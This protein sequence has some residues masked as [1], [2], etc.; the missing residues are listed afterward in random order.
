[1]QDFVVEFDIWKISTPIIFINWD[2]VYRFSLKCLFLK[3]TCFYITEADTHLQYRLYLGQ[4]KI[5]KL[6]D[7][8]ILIILDITP[9]KHAFTQATEN[10]LPQTF[11]PPQYIYL[12][13]RLLIW[14]HWAPQK[15][16][17]SLLSLSLQHP[18]YTCLIVITS[19][20]QLSEPQNSKRTT[21]LPAMEKFWKEL[22]N[23]SVFQQGKAQME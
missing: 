10:T 11:S 9:R 21:K 16:L 23:K 20:T 2:E 22:L 18:V 17:P 7:T 19:Q 8:L 3:F 1:M 6:D 4:K 13:S 5:Q 15:L 12:L 14:Q